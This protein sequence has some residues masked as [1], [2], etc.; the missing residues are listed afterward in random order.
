MI[1]H[2]SRVNALAGIMPIMT[3]GGFKRMTGFCKVKVPQDIHDVL[4]AN[5]DNEEAIKVCGCE[6]VVCL[7]VCVCECVYVCLGGGEGE[8]LANMHTKCILFILNA[9]Y[10]NAYQM[11]TKCIL[12]FLCVCDCGC[13]ATCSQVSMHAMP[14][15][16]G[17]P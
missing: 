11:H 10:S 5:K 3:Y 4:E 1:L 13:E 14:V 9:Y 8:G 2:C 15:G 12:F 7:R 16:R 6:L 17:Q